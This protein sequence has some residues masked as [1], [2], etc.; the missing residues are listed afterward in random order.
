MGQIVNIAKDIC[1]DI[2][3]NDYQLI[4]TTGNALKMLYDIKHVDLDTLY[5]VKLQK[6]GNLDSYYSLEKF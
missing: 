2:G 1:N 5:I 4:I 3:N 6:N